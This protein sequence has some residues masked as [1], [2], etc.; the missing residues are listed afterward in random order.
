MGVDGPAT[1]RP[2]VDGRVAWPSA[3]ARFASTIAGIYGAPRVHAELRRQG[4]RVGR[5]GVERLMRS[6][7]LQGAHRRRRRQGTTVRVAGVGPAEDLVQRDFRPVAIVGLNQTQLT[8]PR[9]L[10]H[11]V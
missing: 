5:K 11:R 1:V 6:A 10:V 9:L 7:G 8:G 2:G 3:S 4:L